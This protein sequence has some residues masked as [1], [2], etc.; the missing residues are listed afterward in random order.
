MIGTVLALYA[1][2]GCTSVDG[3]VR[4]CVQ[5]TRSTVRRGGSYIS[6]IHW[7]HTYEYINVF[8]AEIGR[9]YEETRRLYTK[10]YSVSTNFGKENAFR[11][12]RSRKCVR[13]RHSVHDLLV[14]HIIRGK[15]EK[16]YVELRSDDDIRR[17]T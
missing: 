3:A 6:D 7:H 9:M 4:C 14:S 15:T 16:I 13:T 10:P 11:S 8:E 1:V 12:K 17:Y 5:L 2:Q